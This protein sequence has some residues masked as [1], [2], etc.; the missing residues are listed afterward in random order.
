MVA[1][2]RLFSQAARQHGT[3]RSLRRLAPGGRQTEKR[4]ERC[5]SVYAFTLKH[6]GHVFGVFIGKLGHRVS[7]LSCTRNVDPSAFGD[8][9]R[10]STGGLDK[11][12]LTR[13]RLL[14]CATSQPRV[15]HSDARGK[16]RAGRPDHAA[17]SPGK[18]WFA[19]RSIRLARLPSGDPTNA[20]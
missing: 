9:G 2:Q 13:P 11:A 5:R 18:R 14:T 8:P 12:A 3:P 7:L 4:L 16:I 19:A 10:F 20:A 1:A 6:S 17:P 15:R